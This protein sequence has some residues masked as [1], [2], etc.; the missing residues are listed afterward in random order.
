MKKAII[1]SIAILSILAVGCGKKEKLSTYEETMKEYAT[2]YYNSY[3][4]DVNG[5]DIHQVYISH[6]ENAVNIKGKEYDMTKLEKCKKDS[7][8]DITLKKDSKDI[9]KMEYHMSCE[10]K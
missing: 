9:D 8:V 5:I 2:D 6:L 1:L 7:Y 4:K 3:L 10:E